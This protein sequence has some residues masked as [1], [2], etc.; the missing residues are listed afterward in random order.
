MSFASFCPLLMTKQIANAMINQKSERV[1][2]WLPL[3]TLFFGCRD[4]AIDHC[5]RRLIGPMKGDEPVGGV[6]RLRDQ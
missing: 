4:T 3:A 5:G 6:G 1:A 2:P